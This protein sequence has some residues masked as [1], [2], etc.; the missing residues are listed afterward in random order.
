MS[1]LPLEPTVTQ[2]RSISTEV[3]AFLDE[4]LDRR[5][6]SPASWPETSP[7]LLDELLVGPTEDGRDLSSLLG[8]IARATDTGFDTA[9]QGFLSYIPSGGLYTAALGAL[10]GAVTNQYT[11]AAHASPGMT[12]IEESVIMWMADLFGLPPTAGGVLLSG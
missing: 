10:I 12:A 11:G 1:G 8:D 6:E 7:Q 9:G 4:W 5:D 3:L 2:R